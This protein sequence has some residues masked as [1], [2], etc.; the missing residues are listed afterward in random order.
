MKKMPQFLI[1]GIIVGL[2][3]LAVVVDTARAE[4]H[5]P[6]FGLATPTLGKGQVSSDTVLMQIETDEGTRYMAREMLGYGITE[7][8]QASLTFPLEK[9]GDP[10]T[11]PPRTRFG[12]IMGAFGDVEGSLLWRFHR[13]APAVGTRYESTLIL[14]AGVPTDSKR[15]GANVGPSFNAGVVTGYASR[16]SYWWLGAGYQRY[17]EDDDDRLGDLTYLSAVWGYRPPIFQRDYP[18]PDWRIF[19]EALAEHSQRDRINGVDNP[20]SGGKKLLIGPSVL[21]LYGSWGVSAGVL[22]PVS[23]ELNGQQF[24]EKYRTKLVFTY[25]F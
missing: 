10:L 13:V 1:A 11:N 18:K 12:A 25:W 23:Q 20:N 3:A 9:R 8:V 7:D 15:A 22:F 24:D 21:G 2:P 19:I 14:G 16:T 6:V 5:G 17:F 4:G